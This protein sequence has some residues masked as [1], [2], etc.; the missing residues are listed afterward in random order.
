MTPM[1]LL[2]AALQFPAVPPPKTE[3]KP[4]G[5]A[6]R[7]VLLQTDGDGKVRIQA[8]VTENQKVTTTKT[9]VNNGVGKLVTEEREM[10]VKRFKNLTLAEI[11]NLTI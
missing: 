3:S 4:L 1:L 8:T 11:E 10:P 7:V 6:P 5:P 2:A 9:V